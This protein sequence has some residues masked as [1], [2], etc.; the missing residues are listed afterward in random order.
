[1]DLCYIILEITFLF[2][3][4]KKC[5]NCLSRFIEFVLQDIIKKCIGIVVRCIITLT[6]GQGFELCLLNFYQ[7]NKLNSG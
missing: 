6:T 3:L 2:I 1:M 7:K 4:I 5:N